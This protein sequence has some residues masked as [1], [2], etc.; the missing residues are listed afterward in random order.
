MTIGRRFQTFVDVVLA[1]ALLSPLESR[2]SSLTPYEVESA[3]KKV[4]SLSTDTNDVIVAT[5]I[6]ASDPPLSSAFTS[7]PMD[8]VFTELY[9]ILEFE[10]PTSGSNFPREPL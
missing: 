5:D 7:N 6:V 2:R 10:T 4:F 8:A 3:K 9:R 1:A